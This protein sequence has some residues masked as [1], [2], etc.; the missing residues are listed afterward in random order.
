MVAASYLASQ[1][2]DQVADVIGGYEG[3]AVLDPVGS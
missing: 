1:G 3:W 2:F